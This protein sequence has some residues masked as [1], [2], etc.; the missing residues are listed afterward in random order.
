MKKEKSKEEKWVEKEEYIGKRGVKSSW[1]GWVKEGLRFVSKLK[2]GWIE[3]E[4]EWVE[5]IVR[6]VG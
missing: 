6:V 2:D 5:W 3:R 1:R 4:W